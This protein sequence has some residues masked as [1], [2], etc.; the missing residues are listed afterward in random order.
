MERLQRRTLFLFCQLVGIL[1]GFV[2]SYVIHQNS[3]K[4]QNTNYFYLSSIF[5]CK[6]CLFVSSIDWLFALG[7]S[8]NLGSSKQQLS[9]SFISRQNIY[10]E[11]IGDTVLLLCKVKNLGKYLD[12]FYKLCIPPGENLLYYL[13]WRG[14][15]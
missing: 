8:S 14:D 7:R 10:K 5:P 15:F 9:P 2:G 3:S 6:Y 4:L 1:P 12:Y 13:V 11:E